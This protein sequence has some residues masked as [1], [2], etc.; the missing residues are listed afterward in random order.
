VR[1]TLGAAFVAFAAFGLGA[2]GCT[3]GSGGP[4]AEAARDFGDLGS[5]AARIDATPYLALARAIVDHRDR[6]AVSAPPAAPGRRVFLALWPRGPSGGASGNPAVA[7][8]NGATLADAVADAANAL[9]AKGG[10]GATAPGS[11][12]STCRRPSTG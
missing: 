1:G 8:G 5:V 6:A 4:P 12:S 3:R 11:S 7:T 10:D 2:W 9:A